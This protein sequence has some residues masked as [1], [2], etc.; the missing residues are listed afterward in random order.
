D[1]NTVI[2]S[3]FQGPPRGQAAGTGIILTS[4]G[5]VMT[6]NHVIEGA[7]TIRVSIEGRSGS[8]DADVI[9]ADPTDDVALLQLR[10]VSG[11]PAVS[12]AASS[13]LSIGQRVVAIG[14]ALRRGGTPTVTQ[15]VISALHHS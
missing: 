7:S 11:L 10:G 12:L 3:L 6:N 15:G 13:S 4:S 14:H 1:I 8:V 2:G 9:G 5:Q